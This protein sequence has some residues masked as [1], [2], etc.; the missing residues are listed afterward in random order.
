MLIGLAPVFFRK[1]KFHFLLDGK[2]DPFFGSDDKK[3]RRLRPIQQNEITV[4]K[5]SSTHLF[6]C[7]LNE[8]SGG[9]SS[10]SEQEGH[11]KTV[12]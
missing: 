5:K 8:D 9:G 4:T 2:G 6:F 7:N 12:S 11:F 3:W 10:G 1:E